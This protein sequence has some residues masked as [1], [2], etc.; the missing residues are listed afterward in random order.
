MT[1]CFNAFVFELI[2]LEF[3]ERKDLDL[4]ISCNLVILILIN[5]SFVNKYALYIPNT[6][7]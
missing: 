7:S 6:Y 3:P 4:L 2:V 1:E 5:Q